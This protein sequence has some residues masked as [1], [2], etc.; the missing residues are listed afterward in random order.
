MSESSHDNN[1]VNTIIGEVAGIAGIPIAQLIYIVGFAVF[2]LPFFFRNP[3]LV[4]FIFILVI[5]IWLILSWDDPAGFFE[6]W[7]RVKKLYAAEEEVIF[8]KAGIPR[9]HQPRQKSMQ[10]RLKGKRIQMTR[11]SNRNLNF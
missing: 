3:M 5:T 9:P 2:M 8:N 1:R 11:A 4:F 10:L 6:R 7:T